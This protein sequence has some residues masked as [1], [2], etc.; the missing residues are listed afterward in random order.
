M[1]TT[2][3][4][5]FGEGPFDTFLNTTLTVA[6]SNLA[7]IHLYDNQSATDRYYGEN[8]RLA[9]NEKSS[10]SIEHYIMRK[11]EHTLELCN[12]DAKCRTCGITYKP[13]TNIGSW[14]CRWHPG[15]V[16]GNGFFSCCQ[17]KGF[18]CK[19]CDHSPIV[20]DTPRDRW[21][22]SRRTVKVPRYLH[23]IVKW[24]AESVSGVWS[25]E[26]NPAHSYYGIQRAEVDTNPEV[27]RRLAVIV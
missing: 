20:L 16:Q 21:P 14:G 25:N 1:S 3:G 7:H 2:G 13:L 12:V 9:Y 11:L 6:P 15:Y 26:E 5:G 8:R 24:K 19:R 17:R 22:R 4:E 10:A 18:G 27:S 23:R